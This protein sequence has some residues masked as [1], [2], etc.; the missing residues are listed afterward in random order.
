VGIEL[1]AEKASK[2]PYAGKEKIGIR[3]C[4]DVRS[5]GV[6]LR[7]LGDVIVLMPPLS[8][9]RSEMDQ[10]LGATYEAIQSVTEGAPVPA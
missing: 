10:L 5:R 8:V 1:V 7:P 2:T 6:I 3:V 4:Q 9:N